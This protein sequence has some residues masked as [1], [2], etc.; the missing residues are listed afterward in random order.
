MS[1]KY[2]CM[3]WFAC[4]PPSGAMGK[5]TAFQ[6]DAKAQMMVLASRSR[7]AA[8]DGSGDVGGLSREQLGLNPESR[9][10][11]GEREEDVFAAPVLFGED[12]RV[13]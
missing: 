11:G 10:V 13:G 7:V 9:D 4:L 2:A 6:V 3:T 12:G 1:S 5:R 8:A